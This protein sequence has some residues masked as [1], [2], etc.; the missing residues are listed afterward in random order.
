[1]CVFAVRQSALGGITGDACKNEA[2]RIRKHFIDNPR[3]VFFRKVLQ[4]VCRNHAVE[5]FL[6]QL[7][8]GSLTRVVT[9]YFINVPVIQHTFKHARPRHLETMRFVL[10][11]LAA[12]VIEQRDGTGGDDQILDAF[13]VGK[14]TPP[15]IRFLGGQTEP[16][17]AVAM[18]AAVL[19]SE[20][21][22]A[23]TGII[24]AV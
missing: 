8:I 19:C 6:G 3:N 1:M 18:Q 4:H 10:H 22:V 13:D 24:A 12:A 16:L 9:A 14:K 11:A 2:P 7:A 5:L 15:W 21:T 23:R 17:F 20:L